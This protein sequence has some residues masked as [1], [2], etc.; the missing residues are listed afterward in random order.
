MPQKLYLT[1]FA[2]FL[3]PEQMHDRGYQAMDREDFFAQ[4]L[5]EGLAGMGIDAEVHTLDVIDATERKDK[6]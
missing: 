3:N 4:A 1:D 5:K 6:R 2:V